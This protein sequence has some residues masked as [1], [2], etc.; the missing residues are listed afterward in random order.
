MTAVA[1]PAFDGRIGVARRDVTPPPGIHQNTWGPA[2]ARRS[3]GAHRPLTL[4]ALAIRDGEDEPLVLIALDGSGWRTADDEWHVRSAAVDAA[5]GDGA[6]VLLA[7]SHTHSAPPLGR[8]FEQPGAKLL[9]AYLDALRAAAGDATRDALAGGVDAQI[10]W[11]YGRCDVAAVRDL[12]HGGRR[13]VG[14]APTE[15]ADDT[16]LV[17]RV[18]AADGTSLATIVNYACHPTT[19]AWQNT[20]SS[21]DYVGA[22]RETVEEHTRGA[23]CLFLLGAAGDH[24]P[25]EQ[26]VGDVAI[27]DRHGR[28][29]GHAVLAT[30]ETL[31]APGHALELAPVVESGAPLAPWR[32]VR[33][34]RSSRIEAG[35]AEVDLPLRALPTLAELAER[36][37]GIDEHSLQ[38]RLRR[39]QRRFDVLGDRERVAYPVWTWRVGDA[40]VVAHGGEAYSALQREL[41]RR[42]PGRAIVVANLTNWSAPFYLPPAELFDDPGAYAVWQSAFERGCLEALIE[43]SDAAIARL[44]A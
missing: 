41:R 39:A 20:I 31:P 3:T 2:V 8:E 21:P 25:R 5:G 37:A 38:E 10:E 16:V 9:P 1:P 43:A 7:L 27:P 14:Y 35:V 4:T 32:P 12:V 30:L 15:E 22:M 40:L 13:L 6:R 42:H 18:T 11:R 17:G 19:L 33:R 36:W 29:L 28:A 26:Y 24:A 34:S 23:P 44:L